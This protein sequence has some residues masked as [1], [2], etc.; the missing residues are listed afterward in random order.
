MANTETSPTTASDMSG[1]VQGARYYE[2][3]LRV[4]VDVRDAG[5]AVT[6]KSEKIGWRKWFVEVWINES[7]ADY[8]RVQD[9]FRLVFGA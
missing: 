5:Y 9:H 8:L 4:M 6:Y 1:G 7:G 2:L 3:F